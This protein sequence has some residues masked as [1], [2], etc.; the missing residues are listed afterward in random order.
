MNEYLNAIKHYADFNGRASRKEYWMFILFNFL[1][2]TLFLLFDLLFGTFNREMFM[3]ILTILYG[4]AV[5]IPQ[6]SVTVRRLHD[7][8]KSGYFILVEMIP[9]IGSLW[10]FLMLIK[11]GD[12]GPNIYGEDPNNFEIID[13]ND[14]M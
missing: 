11:E 6:W 9:F 1:I 14:Y 2:S 13:A 10:L 3:G 4:I 7:I 8:G 12:R 5:A